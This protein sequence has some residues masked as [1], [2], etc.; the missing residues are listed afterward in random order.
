MS[1]EL[2]LVGFL[3]LDGLVVSLDDV[4]L[5]FRKIGVPVGINVGFGTLCIRDRHQD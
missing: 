3:G 4:A 2:V 1:A 5:G